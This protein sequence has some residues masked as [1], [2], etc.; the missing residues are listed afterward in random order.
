[1]LDLWPR[2]LSWIP[3]ILGAAIRAASPFKIK[4]L[5]LSTRIDSL[6]RSGRRWFRGRF[7]PVVDEFVLGPRALARGLFQGAFLRHLGEQHRAQT[8]E[9]GLRLWLLV[10]LEIWQRIFVDGEDVADLMRPV[11]GR[12]ASSG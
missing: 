4:F 2:A 5:R 12:C 7:W 6:G 10:N 3:Q 8:W 9:H 1:M 11:E